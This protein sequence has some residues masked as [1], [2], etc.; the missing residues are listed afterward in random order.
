MYTGMITTPNSQNTDSGGWF[1]LSPLRTLREAD[2]ITARFILL[3]P[4]I[5]INILPNHSFIMIT[6]P[7]S[8]AR[9]IESMVVTSL[10][11]FR[12]LCLVT[13]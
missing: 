8:L 6:N 11:P 12:M 2:R 3:S 13:P 4:N 1:G 7:D 9:T 10:M 5:A